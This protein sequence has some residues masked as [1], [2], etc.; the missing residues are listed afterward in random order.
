MGLSKWSHATYTW[1]TSFII[2]QWLKTLQQKA[3]KLEILQTTI[4]TCLIIDILSLWE[5]NFIIT[6]TTSPPGKH[7][8]WDTMTGSNSSNDRLILHQNVE[9]N[10]Y[11]YSS[12]DIFLGEWNRQPRGMETPLCNYQEKCLWVQG[13]FNDFIM[14]YWTI[15]GV[16]LHLFIVSY[17]WWCHFPLK[18]KFP[19]QRQRYFLGRCVIVQVTRM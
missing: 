2:A 16:I 4:N 18:K 5:K 15:I 12:Y 9:I 7:S 8:Y 19:P 1:Y 10:S 14:I 11:E 6:K 17:N 3:P 13:Y